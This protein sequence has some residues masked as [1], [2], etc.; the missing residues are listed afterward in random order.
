MK[1]N[2]RISAK[3]LLTIFIFAIF[4]SNSF[5]DTETL[6]PRGAGS[7]SQLTAEG[8]Y[9]NYRCVDETTANNDTDYVR[10]NGDA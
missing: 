7:L 6:R 8:Q 4:A 1:T 2:L 5:A 10:S 3:V 9:S